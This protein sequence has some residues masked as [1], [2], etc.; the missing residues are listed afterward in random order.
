MVAR[1]SLLVFALGLPGLASAQSVNPQPYAQAEA[2]IGVLYVNTPTGRRFRD[3]VKAATDGH[4]MGERVVL[5]DLAYSNEQQGVEKLLEAVEKREVDI[6]L[7]PTESGVY[8]R[9]YEERALFAKSQIPVI[10]SQVTA[11]VP[12]EEGGWF[13]RTNVNIQ[14]RAHTIYDF[15]NKYWI[16]SIAVLHADTE[17]GRRSENAFRSQLDDEQQKNYLPLVYT[18]DPLQARL[19]LRRVLEARPE[20]VGVFGER[21]DLRHIYELIPQMNDWG[22]P[23]HPIQFTLID[24]RHVG[25]TADDIHFVS[26]T[27][28]STNGEA[29]DDVAAL[30]HDTTTL[31]LNEL[32]AIL[33]NELETGLPSLD[34]AKFRDQLEAAMKGGAV[35]ESSKTNLALA[36]YENMTAPSVYH[37]L[38]GKTEKLELVETVGLTAKAIKK[39][40]L[41]RGR[42]GVWPLI[43]LFLLLGIVTLVGIA[44]IKKWHTGSTWSLFRPRNYP[45]YLLLFVNV[46]VVGLLYIYLV[47]SGNVRYDSTLAVLAVSIAPLAALRANLFET[48]SG[49]EVGAGKIYD[50]FVQWVND[51]LMF[52]EHTETG[53][54]VNLVAYHNSLDGMKSY[55]SN[56][57]AFNRSRIQ[58]AHLEAEVE[59]RTSDTH[60]YLMRRRYGARILLRTSNWSDLQS[61]NLAPEGDHRELEDPEALI[62]TA[63]RRC[64]GDPAHRQK[65]DKEIQRHLDRI[66]DP[67]RKKDLEAALIRDLQGLVGEQGRFRRRLAFLFVLRGYSPNVLT[68]LNFLPVDRPRPQE[69]ADSR[70]DRVKRVCR[71]VARRCGKIEDAVWR[72]FE[73]PRPKD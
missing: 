53:K 58:R 34:R 18:S 54:L 20:A 19:Q 14:R 17:F 22:N 45:F 65:L 57:Y 31:V 49:K 30:S 72:F 43:N 24:A 46:L 64:A 59:E 48:Q 8:V 7:G 67:D 36:G 38:E 16:R 47:E 69:K 5:K 70:W 63:A 42:F 62:R 73:G 56:V 50:D 71:R 13:F 3:A 10:S 12:H 33:L 40:D 25:G 61:D 39:F 41:A 28:P 60:P 52:L 15:L 35:I 29:Y 2:R 1:W 11:N 66:T 51:R 44:D 21:Q 37:L 4:K 23:Y 68:E 32:E 26:V 9:A 6:I 27:E 55:L